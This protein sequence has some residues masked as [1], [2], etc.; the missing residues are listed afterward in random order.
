MIYT[1]KLRVIL[2]QERLFAQSN[3][4]THISTLNI[5][6]GFQHNAILKFAAEIM[7]QLMLRTLW[8]IHDL[9]VNGETIIV[10]CLMEP[11]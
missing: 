9:L 4:L 10:T 11:W 7:D 6:K 5:G 1:S 2:T 3:F 8:K